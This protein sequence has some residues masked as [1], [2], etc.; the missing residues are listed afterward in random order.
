MKHDTRSAA[1]LAVLFVAL[2]I[3]AKVRAQLAAGDPQAKFEMITHAMGYTN[4]TD[5]AFL[6]DGR[7]VITMKGG[8]VVVR[9]RDGTFTSPVVHFKIAQPAASE[10]GLLG[11]IPH[12]AFAQNQTLF[13]YASIGDTP[14]RHKVMQGTLADDDT[15]TVD[16]TPIIDNGLAG[17]A[18]HNGGGLVIYKDQLYVSVGDTGANATPPVNKYGSCLNKPNGKILRVEL[19]GRVP[20]DN[21][22]VGRNQVTGCQDRDIGGFTMEPPDTRIYAWGLRNPFR[23]WID[24]M[25]G[26]LWV[27]DVG[28]QSREE[29]TIGS[30]GSHFGYPFFEGTR[31]YVQ[32]FNSFGG[33]KGMTPGAECTPPLH[34]YQTN[35]PMGDSV[36]GGLIPSGCGWPSEYTSRYIFGD[37][38]SGKVWTLDVAPGRNGV[39]PS[40]LKDFAT[41]KGLAAFRMGHDDALYLVSHDTGSVAKIAPRNRPA[42]CANPPPPDA[43]DGG[44]SDATVGAGT[45][46]GGA[47]VPSKTP[48][49]GGCGC[50]T[51]GEPTAGAVLL[52]CLALAVAG[53]TRR[54]RRQARGI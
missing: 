19:D 48:S 46:S 3:S 1:R 45:G 30:K 9:K 53:N 12:P 32:A 54:R 52:L 26:L 39:V 36:I 29:I 38:G 11:V 31:A 50:A 15:L 34:E 20:T 44:G 14:N 43:G 6:P 23:F 22:L 4:A 24:P 28:E 25:T 42:S 18:N 13:F 21:P 16:A 27:G 51:S 5:I 7:Q 2:S 8:A 49:A 41:L 40:S 47:P 35:G 33:C 10:Q 17:P 37:H